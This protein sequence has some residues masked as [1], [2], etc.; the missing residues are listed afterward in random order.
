MVKRLFT[1]QLSEK[2]HSRKALLK[3]RIFKYGFEVGTTTATTTTPSRDGYKEEMQF[4]EELI[5][6]KELGGAFDTKMRRTTNRGTL[7]VSQRVFANKPDVGVDKAIR[8]TV[9]VILKHMRLIPTA[10]AFAKQ[11]TTATATSTNAANTLSPGSPGSPGGSPDAPESIQQVYNVAA[12]MRR[13][14]IGQH[15]KANKDND[16]DEDE[17]GRSKADRSY[18][19]L[20]SMVEKKVCSYYLL[21][22]IIHI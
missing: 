9:A 6:G 18:Q 20:A 22:R 2:E 17:S 16:D 7:T 10:M 14:F 4:I 13:W 12:K 1:V 3:S 11:A 19:E 15:Q 5:Q 8:A 21:S